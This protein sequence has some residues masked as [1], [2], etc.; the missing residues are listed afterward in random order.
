M[1]CMEVYSCGDGGY[2]GG[3]G[4]GTASLKV[5]YPLPNCHLRF[6]GLSA[7]EFLFDRHLYLGVAEH[8]PLKS[9]FLNAKLNTKVT[10]I[11]P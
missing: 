5:N 8:C 10:P 6:S 11:F 2:P 7:P 4:G 9:N 3:G 1:G